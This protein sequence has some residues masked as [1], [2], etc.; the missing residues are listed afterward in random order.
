MLIVYCAIPYAIKKRMYPLIAQ[1][2]LNFCYFIKKRK[3]LRLK[4]YRKRADRIAKETME[5]FKGE[6]KISNKTFLYL[7]F[8]FGKISL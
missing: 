2:L 5:K 3:Y 4:E 6:Y 7:V 1:P 8:H